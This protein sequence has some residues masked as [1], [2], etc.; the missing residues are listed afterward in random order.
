MIDIVR[1]ASLEPFA[2]STGP[3]DAKIVLVGE[4]F[5]EQ[6]DLV[7][8]PFIG[9]AGQELTRLLEEAKIDRKDCFL[10]NVLPLRPPSN[11][12]DFL[13]GPKKT[14]GKDYALKPLKQGKY[15]LPEFLPQ[16]QRLKQEIE[17]VNPNLV[18]A[19]GNTACWAILGQAK[20]GALRGAVA[21]G[22]LCPS[23][24]I[25]PTYHPAAI[26]YNWSNRPILVADL[27]KAEREMRFP[28]I[29]RPERYVLIN[30]TFQEI[31]N[32][33][34]EHLINAE[35]IS[36]DVETG[37]GMIKCIGFSPSAKYAMV[38][39]FLDRGQPDG[40]YWRTLEEE[41]AAWKI[42]DYILSLP[43]RKVFQNGLFDL[44]Y[45]VP[46]SILP[47]NC[48][49]DTMLLHHSIFPELPKGLGFLGSIYT[50]EPAWK[51]M[52]EDK[53]EFKRDE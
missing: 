37:G 31:W 49:E 1:P 23:H 4:A 26:L 17:L 14:V 41:I 38:I 34:A 46:M 51:L 35:E 52:R 8:R 16:L 48:E 25:L 27:I 29:I 11:N 15:L 20:I 32:W 22:T 2:H 36:V 44:Q 30:P 40:H 53:E 9:T 12:L 42:V 24:K 33:I 6:E 5:G 19:L 43:A 10:T 47:K 39:P 28:E 3:R 18:V 50:N 13:C 21:Y 7:G 45:I